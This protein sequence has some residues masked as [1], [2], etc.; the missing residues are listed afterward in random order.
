MCA[1]TAIAR[2]L[3]PTASIHAKNVHVYISTMHIRQSH[4]PR[5]AKWKA[6]RKKTRHIV[7]VLGT[8]ICVGEYI[9]EQISPIHLLKLQE[10]SGLHTVQMS[11]SHYTLLLK[12][13][14][15][16]PCLSVSSW[17]CFHLFIIIVELTNN[18]KHMYTIKKMW[19]LLLFTCIIP[20]KCI[21]TELLTGF[22]T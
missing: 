1:H 15:S 11:C 6:L 21:V 22:Y 5:M 10:T 14:F 12:G 9:H 13:H 2:A 17:Y 20:L 3:I 7:H 18:H 4:P 16:S 19:F 8:Y